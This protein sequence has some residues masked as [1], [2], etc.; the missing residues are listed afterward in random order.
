MPTSVPPSQSLGP[1]GR[2]GRA[3]LSLSSAEKLTHFH[4]HQLMK[5]EN[6]LSKGLHF[7]SSGS[8]CVYQAFIPS[9]ALWGG[10]TMK[11]FSE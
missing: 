6:I 11:H 10:N 8:G 4:Q 5:A 2:R 1:V 3:L 9:Q 7:L